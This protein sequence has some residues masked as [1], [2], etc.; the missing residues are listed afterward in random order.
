MGDKTEFMHKKRLEEKKTP[1]AKPT[2]PKKMAKGRRKVAKK[3]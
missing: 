3:T 1:A 2:A